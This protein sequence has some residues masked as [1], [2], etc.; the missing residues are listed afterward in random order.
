MMPW[1]DSG[2]SRQP[3]RSASTR[4]LRS[5]QQ[6][7]VLQHPHDT[8]AR[9]AGCRPS[10]P[11][12]ACCI[13][14]REHAPG[15]AAS[16]TSRAVSSSASGVER[17][18]AG[19]GLAA[20]PARP[21]LATARAW[22]CRRSAA[23]SAPARSASR[24]MKSSNASS[25][26]WMSSN[27][28]TVGPS[29]ASASKNRRHA[30]NAST[31]PPAPRATAAAASSPTRGPQVS[32]DPVAIPLVHHDA[33]DRP[34]ASFASA[35]VAPVG[36][37]DPCLRLHHLAQRPERDALAVRERAAAP[38]RDQLGQLLHIGAQLLDQ[39]GLADPR[40]ADASTPTG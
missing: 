33:R 6:A 13:S 25:A 34:P 8:P 20:A 10:A 4:P 28:S 29:S 27:T 17:D 21:P 12:S 31:R 37:E 16:A 23:A 22:P 18:R 40:L 5:A 19:V 32:L 36:L 2:K 14:A 3:R 30:A 39:P 9:T 38:P 24:S 11:S 35:T 26:Q 1:I 7:A 15:P